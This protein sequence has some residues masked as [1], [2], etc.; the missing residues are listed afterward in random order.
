[1]FTVEQRDALR[2]RLVG[3]AEEDERVLAGAAV[4]S[5]AL[6]EGTASPTWT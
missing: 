5:L 2:D 1:M 6:D 3:L 4:G